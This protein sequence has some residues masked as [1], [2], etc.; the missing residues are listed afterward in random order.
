MTIF[1]YSQRF[2]ARST[3]RN[4]PSNISNALGELGRNSVV[5]VLIGLEVL[6]LSWNSNY[7]LASVLLIPLVL[8][9]RWVSVGIPVT[10]MRHFRPFSPYVIPIL[11]WGGLRG[12][13]SVALALSLP[14]G[15]PRDVLLT[16][17]YSIVVFSILVQGLTMPAL[18]RRVLPE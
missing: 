2:A 13:I 15:G 16:I 17:T 11:T 12:G 3:P 8:L 6:V 18:L 10:V 5:F 9:A 14:P 7:L 1:Q 4:G